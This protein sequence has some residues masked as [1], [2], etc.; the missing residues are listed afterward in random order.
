MMIKRKNLFRRMILTVMLAALALSAC[1]RQPVTPAVPDLTP[2]P[3]VP[4][5]TFTPTPSPARIVLYDPANQV[6]PNL[7]GALTELATANALGFETWSALAPSLD[8]VKVMIVAGSLDNLAEL[9]ASAPQTQ[10]VLLSS[11]TAPSANISVLTTNQVHQAF[12]AGYLAVMIAEDFRATTLL[13][14]DAN[15]GLANAFVNGGTYLCGTC[16]STYAPQKY[17]PLSYTLSAGSDASVWS[18]TAAT[19]LTETLTNT[20]FLGPNADLP[21]VLDQMPNAKLIGTDPA[22][23]NKGR[24]VAIFGPDVLAA[25]QQALPDLLAGNGGKT[26]LA[27]VTLAVNNNPDLI[28]PAKLQHLNQVIQDLQTEKIIPLSIP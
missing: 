3:E 20:V 16:V 2:T 24:Y 12:A 15:L 7:P 8:G 25:L 28:S 1:N 19:M 18:N 27:P 23:P 10:F 26:I 4:Q 6:D 9:A 21:E 13:S 5:A 11:M 14:D 17:F 22:S